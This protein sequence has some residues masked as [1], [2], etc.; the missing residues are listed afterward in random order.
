M[1]KN[2]TTHTPR[3]TARTPPSLVLTSR[4]HLTVR[5]THTNCELHVV[6]Q[7]ESKQTHPTTYSLR[8]MC[9]NR[10]RKPR[11]LGHAHTHAATNEHSFGTHAETS[12]TKLS[13]LELIRHPLVA[14]LAQTFC[15]GLSPSGRDKK[16]GKQTAVPEHMH[17]PKDKRERANHVAN[18]RN[19]K[20]RRRRI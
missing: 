12:A 1:R 14:G 18:T 15:L 6:P 20:A 10:I 11:D 7:A 2:H 13:W 17:F 4:R 19:E 5:R 9:E 8:I 3:T 16:L